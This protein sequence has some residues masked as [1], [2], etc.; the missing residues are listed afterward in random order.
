MTW[1]GWPQKG[2]RS[3][4][5]GAAGWGVYHLAPILFTSAL[6]YFMYRGTIQAW[7][8][9]ALSMHAAETGIIL[10]IGVLAHSVVMRARNHSATEA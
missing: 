3:A 7:Y 6:Q 9:T 10:S 8:W 2:G 4:A 5:V 1:C